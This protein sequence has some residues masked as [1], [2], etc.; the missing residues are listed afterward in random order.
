MTVIENTKAMNTMARG[1]SNPH[2]SSGPESCHNTPVN[3]TIS[4]VLFTAPSTRSTDLV[5][6]VSMSFWIR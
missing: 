1:I 6:C 5:V 2:S 4:R 3:M